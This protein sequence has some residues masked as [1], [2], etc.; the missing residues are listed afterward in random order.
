MSITCLPTHIDSKIA[1]LIGITVYSHHFHLPRQKALYN[2]CIAIRAHHIRT[3][4][5]THQRERIDI[6]DTQHNSNG[7]HVR[8]QDAEHESKNKKTLLKNVDIES[9]LES[10]CLQMMEHALGP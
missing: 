8:F 1:V 7:H 4:R 9:S 5:K 10:L 3:C 2:K 6:H